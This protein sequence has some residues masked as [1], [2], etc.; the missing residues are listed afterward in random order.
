MPFG[1]KKCIKTRMHYNIQLQTLQK[2][3]HSYIKRGPPLI[4]LYEDNGRDVDPIQL[5]SGMSE[6]GQG[7]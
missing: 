7:H 1:I 4:Q 6:R 2:A 3:Y 5:L